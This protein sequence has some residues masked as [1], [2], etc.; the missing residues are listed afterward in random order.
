MVSGIGCCTIWFLC[1]LLR[2]AYWWQKRCGRAFALSLIHILESYRERR[3]D[4]CIGESYAAMERTNF[5]DAIYSPVVLA[6][7]AV[8]AGL[9]LIHI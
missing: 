5:Y 4:R 7:N 1:V 6:L 8:V 3:Y 2:W 9:S